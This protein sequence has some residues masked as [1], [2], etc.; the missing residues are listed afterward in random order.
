MLIIAF[1]IDYEIM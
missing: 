1:N